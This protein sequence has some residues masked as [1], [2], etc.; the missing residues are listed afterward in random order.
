MWCAL[1]MNG[2]VVG[3]SVHTAQV[4]NIPSS[5]SGVHSVYCAHMTNIHPNTPHPTPPS[6]TPKHPLACPHPDVGECHCS[7]HKVES[8]DR[9]CAAIHPGLSIVPGVWVFGCG[10][11]AVCSGGVCRQCAHTHIAGVC[12]CA[13][14]V[15]VACGGFVARWICWIDLYVIHVAMLG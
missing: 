13:A 2:G 7:H 11:A 8:V 10:T 3:V 1:C 14:G 4:V 6:P 12:V 9:T 5:S 15:C